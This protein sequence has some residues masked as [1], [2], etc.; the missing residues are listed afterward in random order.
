MMSEL[1]MFSTRKRKLL[2]HQVTGVT[3]GMKFCRGCKGIL[4]PS[5]PEDVTFHCGLFG[6]SLE[7]KPVGGAVRCKVCLEAEKEYLKRKEK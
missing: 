4:A 7:Y 3:C 1:R 6:Q 2:E 5:L